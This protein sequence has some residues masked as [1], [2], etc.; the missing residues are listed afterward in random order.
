MSPREFIGYCYCDSR[1]RTIENI[2]T[3]GTL[4]EVL[5]LQEI[6]NKMPK[7]HRH[8]EVAKLIKERLNGL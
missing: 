4:Q 8:N 3:K 7:F 2:V 5:E 1:F 6:N